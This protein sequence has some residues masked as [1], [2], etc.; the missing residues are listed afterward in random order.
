MRSSIYAI[1]VAASLLAVS[2]PSRK[3]FVSAQNVAGK[4]SVKIAPDGHGGGNKSSLSSRRRRRPF[5]KRRTIDAEDASCDGESS[6]AWETTRR[7]IERL[8]KMERGMGTL[9]L[10]TLSLLVVYVSSWKNRRKSNES[11]GITQD[12]VVQEA[13]ELVCD[14]PEKLYSGSL[15]SIEIGFEDISMRPVPEPG[16]LRRAG[17][18]QSWPE[19]VPLRFLREYPRAGIKRHNGQL[20][21]PSSVGRSADRRE[22]PCTECANEGELIKAAKEACGSGD[23]NI[24]MEDD[25]REKGGSDAPPARGVSMSSSADP[26]KR[27]PKRSKKDLKKLR[28]KQERAVAAAKKAA[29][30]AAGAVA[31][32]AAVLSENDTEVVAPN[33][34]ND[35]VSAASST[36]IRSSPAP[37]DGAAP[38]VEAEGDGIH[39]SNVSAS[40]SSSATAAGTRTLSALNSSASKS[41]AVFSYEVAAKNHQ[42]QERQYDGEL[43][44]IDEE[45]DN[46]RG[47]KRGALGSPR[48][49]IGGQHILHPSPSMEQRMSKKPAAEPLRAADESPLKYLAETGDEDQPRIPLGTLDKAPDQ[50]SR[51]ISHSPLDIRKPSSSE[52]FPGDK[53]GVTPS[54]DKVLSREEQAEA[55]KEMVFSLDES[56]QKLFLQSVLSDPRA[57]AVLPSSAATYFEEETRRARADSLGANDLDEGGHGPWPSLS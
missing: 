53:L 39:D 48:R 33:L 29:Q 37:V 27:K 31:T 50:R 8:K 47:T 55:M 28:K 40:N 43:N 56:C 10:S 12:N 11:I 17:L 26:S 38:E 15:Q 4:M 42:S 6:P 1:V 57:T 21:R 35:G 14:T 18:S 23:T 3:V 41:V 16:H 30:E 36:A 49:T 5:W 45:H 24:T 34:A 19:P 2:I 54:P 9:I 7:F 52:K 46:E 20:A 32:S 51:R 25:V 44:E 22:I 13:E